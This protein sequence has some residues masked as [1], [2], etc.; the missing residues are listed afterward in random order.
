MAASGKLVAAI[1]ASPAVVLA[2]LGLLAGRRY[3]CYPGMEDRVSGG[4]SVDARWCE[5]PVVVDGHIVTSR[6]AGT[7]GLWAQTL[8]GLLVGEEAARKLARSVLLRP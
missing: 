4:P 2:P 8:T 6:A 3:T 5:D 7:A 1:C